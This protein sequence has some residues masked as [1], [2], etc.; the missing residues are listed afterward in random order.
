LQVA[1]N[2]RKLEELGIRPLANSIHSSMQNTNEKDHGEGSDSS[3]L[4]GAD[5]G[6]EVEDGSDSNSIDKVSS[7]TWLGGVQY[8]L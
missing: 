1:E 7:H 4:P 5:D 3:Y 2:N 8:I 6:H